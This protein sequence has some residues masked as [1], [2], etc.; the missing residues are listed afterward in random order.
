MTELSD[1][2]NSI[3]KNGYRA[4]MARHIAQGQK[5]VRDN[6]YEPLLQD[7]NDEMKHLTRDVLTE[8]SC[9]I[10]TPFL[11]LRPVSWPTVSG[12]TGIIH[13]SPKKANVPIPGIL[14]IFVIM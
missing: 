12:M 3:A 2:M 5:R 13:P 7:I 8:L 14:G 1:K 6:D 10:S 11:S 4:N 9:H